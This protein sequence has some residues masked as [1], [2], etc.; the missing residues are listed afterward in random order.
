LRTPKSTRR[1]GCLTPWSLE[2]VRS[3]RSHYL[4]AV[5]VREPPLNNFG[6]QSLTHREILRFY[7]PLALSWIFM[8]IESPTC[9]AIL[10]RLPYR[11]LNMAAFQILMAVSLW[12][13][14][15]VIDL[16][17]TS[18][19]LARSHQSYAQLSRFVWHL[20]AW[21]TMAHMVVVLTPLYWF[22]S[23]TLLHLPYQ[24]AV[25]A[26]GGLAFM[27]PWSGFI[28]WRRYLQGILIR[29]NR[30]RL[31]GI[32][33]AVRVTSMS[34]VGW[35]LYATAGYTHLEG[36]RIAA[37]A[38]ISAVGAECFFAHWASRG[39]VRDVFRRVEEGDTQ[40][41][42]YVTYRKLLT[43]HLPLTA[44]TMVMLC[45]N[46]VISGAISNASGQN[47]ELSLAAWQVAGTLMWLCRT[48]VFALP[49]VII[50]LYRDKQSAAKLRDFCIRIGL[51]TSG[52]MVLLALVGGDKFFFSVV[53][54]ATPRTTDIAHIAFWAGSLMPFIGALQSYVRGM[55]TAHHLTVARFVSVIV[56]IVTLFTMLWIG[57]RMQWPAV[58]NASLALTVSTLA[59][60]GVLYWSWVKGVTRTGGL[61]V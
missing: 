36:I 29:N 24:V 50:T 7:L 59:E 21:V 42:T 43:F 51:S 4:S 47:A 52:A 32:G 61:R 19:T 6:H 15:P 54:Q 58:L 3:T 37:I 23:E 39:T 27:I 44:T 9:T 38:L 12:V 10:G 20:I 45:G 16:L 49:E 17:S 18:T 40:N 55:L 26:R 60:L 57:L 30:T 35:A 14:S 22:L 48:I 33:T 25:S 46:L 2:K 8:A 28:G 53:L 1:F 34:I 13:E 11:E 5:T 56:S 41:D 31:V